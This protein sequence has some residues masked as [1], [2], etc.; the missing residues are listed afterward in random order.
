MTLRDEYGEV[1]VKLFER[2]EHKLGSETATF[3]IVSFEPEL[4][5]DGRK[6]IYVRLAEGSFH[7]DSH[8][9]KLKE[10]EPAPLFKFTPDLV[11]ACVRRQRQGIRI[12][13]DPPKPKSKVKK[14]SDSQTNLFA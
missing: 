9:F 7:W 8:H 1:N 14:S 10:G 6:V 13:D 3:S 4:D 11:A 12:P 5:D 2:F